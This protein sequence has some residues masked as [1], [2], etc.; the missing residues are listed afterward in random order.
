MADG[1]GGIAAVP[2]SGLDVMGNQPA[3]VPS[4]SVRMARQ[5]AGGVDVTRGTGAVMRRLVDR[6]TR[7][8]D[9]CG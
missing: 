9:T 7:S 8:L 4:L 1:E 5:T 6:Q 3:G 2:A